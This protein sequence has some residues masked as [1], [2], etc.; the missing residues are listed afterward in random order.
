[1]RIRFLIPSVAALLVLAVLLVFSQGAGSAQA[2]QSDLQIAKS[3]SP[4]VIA[5]G[6]N[7]SYTVRLTNTTA[8]EILVSPLVDTLPD[9]FEYGGPAPGNEWSKPPDVDGSEVQW[10]EPITVPASGGRTIRY[11][12]H[13][14]VDAPLR[15]EPYT[16]T[17]VATVGGSTYQDEEGLLV[18]IGDVSVDKT[19]SAGR[20]EPGSVVT[21]SVVFSNSGYAEM[22][23]AV[24]TDTLPAGVSF[25]DVTSDSDIQDPPIDHSGMLTWTGPYV[26]PS[27]G[28]YLLKYAVTVPDSDETLS[29]VNRAGARLADGSIVGPAS[30]EVVVSTGPTSVFLPAVYRNW[31]P[32]AFEVSKEANPTAVYAETP[33]NLVT[34][35]IRVE[36]TGTDPGKL[37]DIRDTLPPGFTFVSMLSGSG[38]TEDPVGSSGEIVWNGPF[39]FAGKSSLTVI[40]Q[41]RA[42]SSVGTYTNVANATAIE[43]HP[44]KSP[45]TAVVEVMEPILLAEDWE[46]PSPYWTPF[47][48]YWRLKPEQWYIEAGAGINGSNAL[49]HS[50]FYGVTDPADG[51]HDALYIYQGPGSDTWTNYR[52]ECMT[53]LNEGYTQGLWFRAKYIPSEDRGRH[54]EGYFLNWRPGENLVK[55][56]TVRDWEPY[57]YHFSTLEEIARATYTLHRGEWYKVAVEVSGNNIKAYIDGN[58]VID[59]DHDLFPTGSV[60]VYAYKVANAAWDNLLVTPLP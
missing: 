15:A 32:A 42:S 28:E 43:G 5:P 13:V 33:G 57:A 59:V 18:A 11:W 40:Y 12:V 27:H 39:D 30:Q 53:I 41:A 6:V 23:L 50:Y 9:G 35:T 37:Q 25:L 34:Y 7:V 47:L 46:D 52:Y 24:V 58:L 51:A 20:V 45:G 36:N 4:E 56:M 10:T 55:L 38:V 21:Y 31:A 44:P 49:K 16:N 26:I 1:M 54:I 29:L 3:V 19:A 8:A 2:P 17:V 14:P 48:N 22:P 60:G